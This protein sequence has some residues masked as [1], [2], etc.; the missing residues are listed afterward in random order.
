MN[1]NALLIVPVLVFGLLA[2]SAAPAQ[3]TVTGSGGGGWG[4]R[5]AYARM[6]DPK[7]VETVQAQIVSVD[8]FTPA[9]K[10]SYGVHALVKTNKETLSVH[11][12]PAWYIENQELRL[13]P[14]DQIEVKGS[15]INFEGKPALI[16]A[17]IRKGDDVVVLRD[18]RGFP[19]WSGW[20]R[21]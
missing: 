9:K 12:G 16:A 6:Y 21:R 10:M 13:A 14:G 2:A 8:R 11:L 7:T 18:V 20:R 19:A 5:M 3:D 15:R 17:E 4:P 1:F